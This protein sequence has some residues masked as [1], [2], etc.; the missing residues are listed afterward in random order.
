MKN[1]VIFELWLHAIVVC[2]TSSTVNAIMF[3]K[4][5]IPDIPTKFDHTKELSGS[6]RC[7]L[8]NIVMDESGSMKKPQQFLNDKDAIQ[9]IVVKL[10]DSGKVNQKTNLTPGF[11]R[12]PNKSLLGMS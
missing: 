2:L 6:D 11:Y 7:A 5:D 10:R 4:F 1:Q 8:I 9:N 12:Y 3:T